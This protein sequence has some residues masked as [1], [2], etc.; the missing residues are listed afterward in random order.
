[1]KLETVVV[2]GLVALML[3]MPQIAHGA[4][5][6]QK[7]DAMVEALEWLDGQQRSDGSWNYWTGGGPVEDTAVTAAAVLAFQEAKTKLP[8][9]EFEPQWNTTISDGMDFIMSRA[10]TY[11]ISAEPT[12]NPDTNLNGIGVKFVPGGN[13][14]R[15]TYVTGLVLPALSYMPSSATVATGSQ[16]GRTYKD[17]AQDVVDYFAY[18][19]ADQGNQ[20]RGGWRYY[21]DYGQS[22]NSTA[23]WPAVGMLFAE[24]RMGVTIPGF[25]R[26]ELAHWIEYIQEE[27]AG[28]YYGA[29]WY[30]RDGAGIRPNQ[31]K[32]GGL[33]VEMLLAED[34]TTGVPF[35]E[36]HWR[37]QAALSYIDGVWKQGPHG[38]WDGNFG[39]PYAM[40]SVYKGLEGYLG[41]DGPIPE[42][43]NLHPAGPMDDGDTW[44]WWEDYCEWL[45]NNQNSSGY[46]SGY[47]YWNGPLAAAW[48]VNILAAT[49]TQQED[50]I[51]E[52]LTMAAVLTSAAG[53]CGYIRRRRRA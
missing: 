43:S 7:I 34:D 25:V 36:N 28:G 10:T 32:T 16:A 21:A 45:V 48:N 33:L 51:P 53:L 30:D 44:N 38:T 11:A 3:L 26:D 14:N 47:S 39:H 15:D 18:G 5:E 2:G 35:D 24:S 1:M 4:S 19:Q 22:D 29:S 8:V 6:T 37:V 50:P 52:P 27:D 40:W 49:A 13:N 9:G 12:G 31:S 20:A 42:I 41:T 46:W 17:V 23:Q